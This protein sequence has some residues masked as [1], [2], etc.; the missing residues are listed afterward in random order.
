MAK[1]P[2]FQLYTGD[3]LKD[4][5]LSMC[6]PATRGIWMDL[7]C[8]MHENDRSGIVTGPL[9]GLARLCRCSPEE[10]KISLEELK[11]TKTA[12]V[13]D[14]HKKITVTNR[15]MERESKE[16]KN[17]KIRQAKFRKQEKKADVTEKS[18]L[19]SSSSSSSSV[20]KT[21]MSGS[22]PDELP[23]EKQKSKPNGYSRQAT[24]I[25]DFLNEKAGR[26]YR[27]VSTNLELV[28]ARMKEGYEIQDFK[29]VIAR[30]VREWSGDEKMAKFLRPA[31]LFNKTK[32]AQYTGEGAADEVKH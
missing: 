7:I 29:S 3:W 13:T 16:R 21:S 14:H 15:R 20:L 8:A 17:N 30:K 19:H 18:R 22:E 12:C 24:E 10:M 23:P 2:A 11:D 27:P 5:N 28:I 1:N 31:T 25:I 6:S 32:F 26:S 4:P 9:V